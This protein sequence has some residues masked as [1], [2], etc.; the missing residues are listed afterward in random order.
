MRIEGRAWART[1]RTVRCRAEFRNARGTR[2]EQERAAAI[3]ALDKKT[4]NGRPVYRV[5]CLGGIA[6][7]PTFGRGEHDMWIE[8]PWLWTLI[9][10]KRF[11]CPFHC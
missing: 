3:A 8:E 6:G 7:G 5:R 1:E 10:L 11:M 9:D 4:W 2:H